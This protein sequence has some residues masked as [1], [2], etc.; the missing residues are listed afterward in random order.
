MLSKRRT[1]SALFLVC[2]SANLVLHA[3]SSKTGA[4]AKKAD[5]H[6]DAL[7]EER[8]YPEL[9]R[10][11]P[12]AT[13]D[14]TGRAYFEGVLANRK[15]ELDLSISLL[16]PLIPHLKAA[17]PRRAAVALRTLADDYVKTFRYADADRAYSELLAD[18]SKQFNS[19]DRKSLDDDAET[20]RLLKDTPPQTVDLNGPFSLLTHRSKIGT[21]DTDLTV[22]GV[23]K[24]WI[25]DT[26]ANFSVLTE[27]VARQMGL[28]LS[29]Q[30]AKVQGAS[31]AESNLHI[32]IIPEMKIGSAI[33]RNVVI[34]VLA[35]K[36]LKISVP[37]TEYQID[38]ILGYPVLSALGELTFTSDNR[39]LTGTGGNTVGAEFYMQ[40]LNM[41]LECRING[42]DLLMLFDTG[43]DSTTFT[44]KY[45][46]A[47]SG[48]FV[49]L[50][51]RPRGIGGAGGV[52][53]MKAYSLPSVDIGL[54]N[55]TATV[56]DVTVAAEP[57]GTDVD[58]LYGTVGRDLT[59]RFKS[60]TV[61]FKSMRF[62]LD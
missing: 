37:S 14:G 17:S 2:L 10:L 53:R 45:Y 34:L 16:Q 61:D 28:K 35:D 1:L 19:A 3:E 32:A 11:L 20:N 8:E 42:R 24:S 62:R 5:A 29:E 43:A 25:L 26:G 46:R 55:Q 39:L 50:S 12:Q 57:I 44:D 60:F 40:Q 52:K 49:H 27:S 41:L 13:L 56:K 33:A 51:P 47:F 58:L 23:T 59:K 22:N 30:T 18:F 54:G 6:L 15:N 7:V 9:E 38:A 4:A 48:Q 31:G 21:I 36:A